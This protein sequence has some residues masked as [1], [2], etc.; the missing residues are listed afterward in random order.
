MQRIICIANSVSVTA[1]FQCT[2]LWSAKPH[3]TVSGLLL[4]GD[5]AY[6]SVLHSELHAGGH[7]LIKFTQSGGHPILMAKQGS[8]PTLT[9]C[10]LKFTDANLQPTASNTYQL[11]SNPSDDNNFILAVFNVDYLVQGETQFEILLLGGS[12]QLTIWI[13]LV[14]AIGSSLFVAAAMASIRC[15]MQSQ[16]STTGNTT[17]DF[18]ATPN[19]EVCAQLCPILCNRGT[20][21]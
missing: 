4:P 16:V 18:E 9:D 5:W 13:I 17:L 2:A 20:I 21:N 12:K 19:P 6:V 15:I 7:A 11:D 14:I 10:Y 8:Y 3:N 1:L